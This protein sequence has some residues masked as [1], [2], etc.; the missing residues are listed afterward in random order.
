[1]NFR[2]VRRGR[3]RVWGEEE[4]G[5]ELVRFASSEGGVAMGEGLAVSERKAG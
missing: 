4:E 5:G 2:N 1:M 3:I